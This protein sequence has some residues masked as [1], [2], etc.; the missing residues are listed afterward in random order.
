MSKVLKVSTSSEFAPQTAAPSSLKREMVATATGNGRVVLLPR[1]VMKKSK[2]EVSVHLSCT[3]RE[4]LIE[5]DELPL[6]TLL[7]SAPGQYE[8]DCDAQLCAEMRA[9]YLRLGFLSSLPPKYGKP[10]SS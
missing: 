6:V 7:D 3:D 4:A 9:A 5:E 2:E 1:S 8:L 10:S